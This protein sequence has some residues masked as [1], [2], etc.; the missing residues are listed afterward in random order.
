[1]EE[2]STAVC[3]ASCG[4]SE[5]EQSRDER[6]P[7]SGGPERRNYNLLPL[8][9]EPVG[10]CSRSYVICE[11]FAALKQKTL[12]CSGI[13]VCFR[14]HSLDTPGRFVSSPRLTVH[15]TCTLQ[16]LKYFRFV[17][18]LFFFSAAFLSSP[19]ITAVCRA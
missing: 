13:L 6:N 9:V 19:T 4:T 17:F 3:G 5:S 12:L 2:A 14:D 18:P 10:A 8:R 7:G 16:A 11:F 15:F 1:M